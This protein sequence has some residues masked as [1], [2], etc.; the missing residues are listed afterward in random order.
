MEAIKT[1][2]MDMASQ[3]I[4][5]QIHAVQNESNT[6]AVELNLKNEGT[7]WQVP[8][9]VTAG[10]AFRKPDGTSGLY[11]VLPNGSRAVTISGS[12]VKAVLAPQ[13]L[14]VPGIV[15]A[16]VVFIEDA[17]LERLSSFP[18]T[19][20]VESD[21]SAGTAVSNNYYQFQN[22]QQINEKLSALTEIP[23]DGTP[24]QVLTKT[25]DGIAWKACSGGGGGGVTP[26]FSIG[27]VTTLEPGQKATASI[28]GTAENPVL[29]MGI[30]R[31]VQGVQGKTPVKGVDYLTPEELA[32]MER[33]VLAK[34]PTKLADL[35]EDATHRI[36]TDAEKAKWNNA[37]E[38]TGGTMSGSIDMGGKATVTNLSSPKAPGDAVPLSFFQKTKHITMQ[39][40]YEGEI[41]TGQTVTVPG[42]SKYTCILVQLARPGEPTY[43]TPI[44]CYTFGNVYR[45][46]GGASYVG[47]D[48]E[49]F[50][51]NAAVG[52]EDALTLTSAK[53]FLLTDSSTIRDYFNM[54]I[55][56]IVGVF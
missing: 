24:G 1:L 51:V 42:I 48:A 22:L 49:L 6:R 31:G 36:V 45:G 25:Y 16:A 10:V 33:T 34:V 40:L 3:N 12:R 53:L 9:G 41:A 32:E 13:V 11:D 52:A 54:Y 19:I 30:P 29:N 14:Q 4:V 37:L 15:K 17:T 23:A 2:T 55:H 20:C 28:T 7:E 47:E 39:T 43:G 18:F 5:M 56:K 44:A 21:P 26:T 38:K 35:G 8:S 50:F 27:T 46:T